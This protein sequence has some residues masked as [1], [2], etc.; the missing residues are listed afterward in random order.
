MGLLCE[1]FRF[2]VNSAMDER[3]EKH[4][5]QDICDSVK[6]SRA[7]QSPAIRASREH[8]QAEMPIMPMH[9]S[10]GQT[11]SPPNTKWRSQR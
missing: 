8:S 2:R 3:D 9:V 5:E 7:G 11:K 10:E 6:G 1:L 4:S